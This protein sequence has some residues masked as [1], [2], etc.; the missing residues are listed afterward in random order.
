MPWLGI[1]G[2]GTLSHALPRKFRL[3]YAYEILAR[4]LAARLDWYAALQG[5]TLAPPPVPG[6][7]EIDREWLKRH[8]QGAL[9]GL[10]TSG[11]TGFME[12]CH[13]VS[14]SAILKTQAELLPAA[15][16][17]QVH[18]FGWPIGVVFD[19]REEFRPR[20]TNE[21]ILAS[22]STA[23]QH[24]LASDGMFDYWALTKGGD[25]YTLTSLPEDDRRAETPILAMDTRIRRATEAVLHCQNLY[26]VLGIAPNARVTL[27]VRYGGL[28]G[29]TLTAASNRHVFPRKN[30]HEDAVSVPPITFRL[31]AIETDIVELVKKLCEPLFV[32][33]DFASFDDDV[34]RESVTDFVRGKVS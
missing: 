31:G 21:G 7:R 12:V 24:P 2:N 32:I 8:R 4:L 25:F 15:R 11:K 20:P 6:R 5:E 26:K 30:I 3:G 14:D 17:A 19:N 29:R 16:Q 34:Y 1:R 22:I 13:E 33:F 9:E 27:T 28:R 18:I 10:S 23:V